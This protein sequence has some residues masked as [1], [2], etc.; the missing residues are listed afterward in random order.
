MCCHDFGIDP[1]E[2]AVGGRC[3]SGCKSG[4][5]SEMGWWFEVKNRGIWGKLAAG[6]SVDPFVSILTHYCVNM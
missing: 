6:A 4:G 1:A 2:G 5:K 3:E